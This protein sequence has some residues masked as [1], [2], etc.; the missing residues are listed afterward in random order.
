ALGTD[1]RGVVRHGAL[2][3]ILFRPEAGAEVLEARRW[4]EDRSTG[5]GLE[6]AR[7]IEAALA[8]LSHDPAA[9]PPVEGGCRRILLRRFPYSLVYRA[10][11][12]EILVVAVF[13][14]RR[15]PSS[16]TRRSR[17]R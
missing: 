10:R 16:L 12:D 8:A 6:F 14:H 2:M 7:S 1:T 17:R 13:H 4:Y 15:S 9:H 3:R 5:L 11:S